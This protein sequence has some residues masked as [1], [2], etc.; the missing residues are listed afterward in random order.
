MCVKKAAINSIENKSNPGIPK[1]R[2]FKKYPKIG[3]L[4]KTAGKEERLPQ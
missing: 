1:L 4:I 3:I 2:L